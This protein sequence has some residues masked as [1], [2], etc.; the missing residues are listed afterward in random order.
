MEAV[1]QLTLIRG[2]ILK[3][4]PCLGNDVATSRSLANKGEKT[5]HGSIQSL[6]LKVF[7]SFRVYNYMKTEDGE[8]SFDLLSFGGGEKNRNVNKYLLNKPFCCL[9]FI[10]NPDFFFL[11]LRL[12]GTLCQPS[13]L[14]NGASLMCNSKYS[15]EK[16][17]V[18]MLLLWGGLGFFIKST[19]LNWGAN[20][21]VHSFQICLKCCVRS[22]V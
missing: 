12:S 21:S 1:N 15:Q 11:S 2:R 14:E 8:D 16:K 10:H 18:V 6:C 19:S 5:V 20:E 22:A 17:N 13:L 7:L 4:A 9:W 3:M